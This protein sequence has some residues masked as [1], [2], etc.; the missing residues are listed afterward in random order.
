MAMYFLYKALKGGYNVVYEQVQSGSIFMFPQ[1][2]KCRVL[3]GKVNE[4]HI[5]AVSYTHL[6]LPTICSV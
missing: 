3:H 1:T 2:G 4:C 5:D 6:T